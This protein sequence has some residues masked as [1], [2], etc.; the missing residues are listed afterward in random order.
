MKS[1]AKHKKN[2]E[3]GFILVAVIVLLAVITTGASLFALWVERRMAEALYAH[4]QRQLALDTLSTRSALLYFLSTG[5]MKTLGVTLEMTPEPAAT[6]GLGLATKRTITDSSTLL[7]LDDRYYKGYGQCIFSV[8][9]EAGLILLNFFSRTRLSLLLG[10]LGVPTLERAGLM[11]T[12]LDYQDTNDLVRLNG[13]ERKQYEAAGKPPPANRQLLTPWEIAAV[14]GWPEKVPI[15]Q[16]ARLTTVH[17]AGAYSINSA[18]AQ[19]IQT[20]P[21]LNSGDAERIL[22]FREMHPITSLAHLQLVVGKNLQHLD[23]E[24][25]FTPSLAQRITF[26]NPTQNRAEEFHVTFTPFGEHNTPWIIDGPVLFST[27][28]ATGNQ[29]GKKNTVQ[30]LAF[31]QNTI[32]AKKRD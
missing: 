6:S 13:A 30:E 4:D 31:F 11:S 23:M 24:V 27:I 8:Q 14:L 15:Q 19:T 22:Q 2:A 28:G 17:H 25:M 26:W 10:Q 32:S 16:L 12:L 7:R 29:A 9:D 3:Q 1:T 18:V 20:L 21:G 5:E